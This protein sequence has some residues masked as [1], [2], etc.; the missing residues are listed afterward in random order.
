MLG[1]PPAAATAQPGRDVRLGRAE[2][3]TQRNRRRHAPS[4]QAMDR[5]TA[6]AS[7]CNAYTAYNAYSAYNP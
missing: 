3:P 2:R 4:A 5:C 1:V 7:A 6:H